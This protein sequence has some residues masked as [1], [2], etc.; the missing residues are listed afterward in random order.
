MYKDFQHFLQTLEAKG[1]LKKVTHPISP[2]LE[3]TEIA[4][5]CM[6]MPGGGPAILFENPQGHEIP[7][8]INTMGSKRRMAMALG[9]N[10]VNEIAEELSDMLQPD[11]P[12][13]IL[14]KIKAIRK[15]ARFAKV[16]P[17]TVTSGI[18]QEVILQNEE[19]NLNRLPIMKCWPE[20]GGA[21]ITLPLVFTHDP[22]T[23]KRNVGMYRM[24]VYDRNTTGMH[25]QM[26]K[27][28]AEHMRKAS[29][30]KQN[31]E[32]AVALGGDPAYIFSAIAPLP[33]AIDEMLFAGFL[34]RESAKL[35]KAKTVDIKVPADAEIVLEGYVDPQEK[36]VEG[37]F[38]DHTGY[39]SLA[40]HFPVFHITCMTMREKPVYPS[41]I[42]GIPPMEDAY[43]GG[44]VERI[45]LP[46]IRLTLPEIVNIHL[47]P[48]ACFHNMV[49]VSIRKR[50]PGHAYKVMNAL[51]GLGQL[52]FSKFIFVFED[53]VDVQNIQD[54]LFRIGANCDPERDSLVVRGPVDQLDHA[55]NMVGFGGKI[56][57]D[58]THK[59]P[60]EGFSREWPGLIKMSEEIKQKVD[61]IWHELNI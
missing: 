22:N 1:E 35:V 26:H 51:W 61:K 24:Q 2:S 19:V 32:V 16:P 14:E 40:D 3:M 17:K 7:V 15:F 28:G 50:Y 59:W 9:V 38:G 33:P 45:F 5:R 27:V 42:V 29:E 10:D 60:S 12:A 39:Y 56:G 41:T 53:D 4:D 44:A 31:I 23:G 20:D 54:V 18:C 6:K 43:M 21:F 25:W 11:I 48:E 8:A 52:M 49:F 46:L 55:T 37:P 58:C 34:R 57:F 36:R 47:P 13:G 30:K